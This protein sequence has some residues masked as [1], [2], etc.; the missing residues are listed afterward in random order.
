M[1]RLQPSNDDEDDFETVRQKV[2]ALL[3]SFGNTWQ[4]VINNCSNETT[5]EP[6]HVSLYTVC[7]VHNDQLYWSSLQHYPIDKGLTFR[8]DQFKI[9]LSHDVLTKILYEIRSLLPNERC[10]FHYTNPHTVHQFM[11]RM[12]MHVEPLMHRYISSIGR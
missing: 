2:Y 3:R 7:I 6:C 10:V 11:I 9:T 8:N 5:E 1:V 4:D 12:D